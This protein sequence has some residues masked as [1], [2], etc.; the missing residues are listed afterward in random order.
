MFSERHGISVGIDRVGSEF[1]LAITA[2][3][4]LT[5][6]DYA[7]ITP[8]LDGA[9]AKVQGPRVKA[10]VDTTELEGWELRA[11]WDDF[12]LGL[13]HGAEFDKVALYGKPGWQEMAAKVGSWFLSGEVAFFDNRTEALDWLQQN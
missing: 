5:H 13:K 1:Y 11:A 2:V 9:L 3:G 12:K 8:I 10:L 4:K 7:F 6:E